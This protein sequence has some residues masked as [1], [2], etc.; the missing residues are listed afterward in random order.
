MILPSTI[1]QSDLQESYE[2]LKQQ[3][4]PDNS[5]GSIQETSLSILALSTETNQETE[6]ATEWLLTQNLK[7]NLKDTALSLLALNK[8]K[9]L[10]NV[11][12][13]IQELKEFL[14]TKHK[15][16]NT[17][18][19]DQLQII[20]PIT[21]KNTQC[22]L[23]YLNPDITSETIIISEGKYIDKN[24]NWFNPNLDNQRLSITCPTQ[25]IASL[26]TIEQGFFFNKHIIQ[27]KHADSRIDFIPPGCYSLS[28]TCNYEENAYLALALYEI[29]QDK[30]LLT[31][32]K[33]ETTD[34]QT[35]RNIVLQKLNEQNS[36]EDNQYQD[37]FQNPGWG[38]NT[39]SYDNIYYT[40]LALTVTQDSEAEAYL[41]K[42]KKQDNSFGSVTDTAITLYA[43]STY[44]PL[45]IIPCNSDTD[46]EDNNQ[47]T[48]DLCNNPGT[49]DSYCTNQEKEDIDDDNVPNDEDLCP[50]DACPSTD[51]DCCLGC[52]SKCGVTCATSECTDSGWICNPDDSRCPSEPCSNQPYCEDDDY[53]VPPDQ[54]E[55]CSLRGG[56]YG[57]CEPSQCPTSGFDEE[58]CLYNLGCTE[59]TDRDDDPNILDCNDQDPNIGQCTGC[60]K[61]SVDP[62]GDSDTG[63]CIKGT[64]ASTKCTNGCDLNY[65]AENLITYEKSSLSNS[66]TLEDDHGTCTE[67]QCE[68]KTSVYSQECDPDDDDDGV[69]DSAYPF[70]DV[71][72]TG[73][74]LCPYTPR[75]TIVDS[76]GCSDSDDDGIPDDKDDCDD[77]LP[78]CTIN[79]NGCSPDEDNDG[80]C[81]D[82]DNCSDT[83]LDCKVDKDINSFYLGCELDEDD[84]EICDGI[85]ECPDTPFSCNVN[86]EG[87]PTDTNNPLCSLDC[88]SCEQ[89]DSSNEC[90]SCQGPC[91]WSKSMFIN[92][93][94]FC[95]SSK[96]C[97]DYDNKDSCEEDNCV[98]QDCSWVNN[99][100]CTDTDND[101]EC[102][103]TITLECTSTSDCDLTKEC[104]NNQCIPVECTQD[105]DCSSNEECENNYCIPFTTTPSTDVECTEDNDC[106]SSEECRNNQC[107][108]STIPTEDK[109]GFPWWILIILLLLAGVTFLLYKKGILKFKKKPK[110]QELS[111]KKPLDIFNKPLTNNT[112]L[113]KQIPL[114]RPIIKKPL[115]PSFRAPIKLPESKEPSETMLNL[116]KAFKDLKKSFK[117]KPKKRTRKKKI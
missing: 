31:F 43:I 26:I 114:Q 77:T 5:F 96:E 71:C 16:Q 101:G 30:S 61:C 13:K 35:L 39:N 21:T 6:Q 37:L 48:I 95:S 15:T 85:D 76:N 65:P 74:D 80:V 40:A 78:G 56:N 81:D 99:E 98:I 60:A 111:Y 50:V 100:C 14:N 53:C 42:Q 34:K 104:I 55:Y 32:I 70:E 69:C 17:L 86:S 2:W 93:C 22:T 29:D 18:H 87:C 67:K 112:Q 75:N 103:S 90:N 72:S 58:Y 49:E 27:E 52:A 68:I 82:L 28:S 51:P 66:C 23:R 19:S 84:D 92:D 83:P 57:W 3:K 11:N 9:N 24:I 107:V 105:T 64:C 44:I 46:C 47:L 94:K 109:K 25:I 33:S 102:D 91:Y 41:L 113:R 4:Q 88:I 45:E 1:P 59:D 36:L 7:S 12:F 20:L 97:D 89:A 62:T 117:K 115:T 63:T 8:V 10:N 73:P 108:S 38:P 110:N 116:N 79:S 106:L 54:Q